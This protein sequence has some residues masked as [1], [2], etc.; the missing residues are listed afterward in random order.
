MRFREDGVLTNFF[1]PEG[2]VELYT[3][4]EKEKKER[5]DHVKTNVLIK[6]MTRS[7]YLSIYFWVAVIAVS[8]SLGFFTPVKKKITQQRRRL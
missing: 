8:L 6:W 3:P 7:L 2:K 1:T 5:D 4:T